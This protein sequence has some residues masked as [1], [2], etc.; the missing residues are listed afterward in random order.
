MEESL[1]QHLVAYASKYETKN[2]IDADPSQFMHN[3]SEAVLQ[4]KAAFVAAALSYGNRRQFIPKV[5]SLLE[6]YID[7]GLYPDDNDECFYR[8]HTNRMV[9]RFLTVLDEIYL[10]YGSIKR[11]MTAHGVTT[12]LDAVKT[13][14]G[15]FGE[16]NASDLIPKNANSACKRVCMFLRWMVRGDSPV[17]IGLWSDIIDKSTLIMPMDTHVLQE[18][19][20]L[21]LIQSKSGSMAT[22]VKL[23][24]TLR[25]A[26]PDDP[27]R[28]DFAL[29]GIGV[30]EEAK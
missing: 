15:Y 17:D 13:I 8:L 12:G 10:T 27:T 21:G 6:L 26:F 23:T 16:R 2:F 7:R 24:D 19:Q 1:K 22:A 28:A 9:R 5:Y 3:Y 11:L 30:D 25:Q 4:E 18:A 29:F 14:T 20:R